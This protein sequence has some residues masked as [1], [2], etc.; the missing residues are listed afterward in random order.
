M[1]PEEVSSD[2]ETGVIKRIQQ[3]RVLE[4]LLENEYIAVQD[5]MRFAG[6]SASVLI[7]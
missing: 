1:P 3:I 6:V 5:L 7:P 4:M 2:I